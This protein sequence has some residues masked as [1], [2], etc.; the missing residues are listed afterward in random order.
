MAAMLKHLRVLTTLLQGLI[1]V[2][3][4]QFN[5]S[6]HTVPPVLGNLFWLSQIHIPRCETH[7]ETHIYL[8]KNK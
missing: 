2:P 8:S 6:Q 4:T 7:K 3:S 5:T 1:L